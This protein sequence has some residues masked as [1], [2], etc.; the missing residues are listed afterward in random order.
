VADPTQPDDPDPGDHDDMPEDPFPA[1]AE[2]AGAFP[3]FPTIPGLDL[4]KIDMNELFTILQSPGPVNWAIASQLATTVATDGEQEGPVDAAD[5]T[6]MDELARAAQTH[7]VAETGLAATFAAPVRAM[8]RREWAELHL[9]ALRPVLESLATTLGQAFSPDAM[10]DLLGGAMSDLDPSLTDTPEGVPG[11]EELA[12]IMPMMAPLLL[13]VQAGSMIGYLAR[14][15]LGR[16]DLP[17]PTTDAPSLAFVVPNLDEF[18]AAWSLERADLRFYVAIHEVVHAATRSVPWVRDRLVSLATEYVSSY[19]L[20]P[21]VLEGR[22]GEGMFENL[23]PSDPASIQALAEHP[24]ELL[25][26]LRSDH[27]RALLERA[28]VFHGVL[29]GYADS[30]LER[31]GRNLLPSFDRIHEA[32]A[33]HRI[34][35]GEAERFVVGLLGLATGR[36]DYERGAEFCRGVVER[37]GA[38]GLN[39]LWEDPTMEPTPN[40]VVAPGLWLARIELDLDAGTPDPGAQDPDEGDTT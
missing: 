5:Q 24:E 16:Y 20:D 11:P 38:E 18:E 21:N 25:G 22:L 40:E 13:G 35:R 19:E 23:D 26:A 12:A 1:P 29:E 2:G 6:Q 7:V 17:L 30:V 36:D 15:A 32:M 39:R 14:H 8:G 34:E 28:R 31:V 10:E 4:S 3:G 9:V 27:Q 33:R 37:A